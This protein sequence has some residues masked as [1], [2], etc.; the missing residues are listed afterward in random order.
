MFL[1]NVKKISFYRSQG[2]D[3]IKEY[4]VVSYKQAIS[5]NI[6][7]MTCKTSFA[8]SNELEEKH[9]G[10]SWFIAT[11]SQLLKTGHKENKQGTASVS[12][13]L[14]DEQSEKFSIDS[15]EGEC[16]CYLPLN[17]KTG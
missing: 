16:F 3:F 5:N 12:V 9:D 17:I 2:N 6:N 1:N 14:I 8:H 7:L 15:I 13:K 11:N 4:E 10:Q